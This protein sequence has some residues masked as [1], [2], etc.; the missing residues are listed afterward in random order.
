M[1]EGPV[2]MYVIYQHILWEKEREGEWGGNREGPGGRTD[3][4]M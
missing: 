2:S 3:K 1:S 4:S